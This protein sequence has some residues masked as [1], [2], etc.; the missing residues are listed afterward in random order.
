MEHPA[1]LQ[2]ALALEKRGAKISRV[3][4][5]GQGLVSLEA[6]KEACTDDTKLVSVMLANNET[7]TIQPVPEIAAW[8][9]AQGILMHTDAL[10]GRGQDTRG[11]QGARR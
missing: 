8:A 2:N 1:I 10:P 4:V 7:G 5:D 3:P 11:R 6:L 9:E